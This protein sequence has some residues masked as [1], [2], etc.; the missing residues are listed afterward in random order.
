MNMKINYVIFIYFLIVLKKSI[1]INHLFLRKITMLTTISL[2]FL[3]KMQKKNWK[4]LNQ[5]EIQN[6]LKKIKN[7]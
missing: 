2:M 1:K 5:K 3:E 6:F 7:L 4:Y